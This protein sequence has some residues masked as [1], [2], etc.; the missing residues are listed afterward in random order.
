MTASCAGGGA[1]TSYSWSGPGVNPSAGASQVVNV[2]S[3]TTFSVIASNAAGSSAPAFANVTVAIAPPSACAL[4]ANPSQLPAGGGLVTLTASCSGGGAP[5]TY[6]WSGP[7]V[8]P[9]AGASQV[10]NVTATSTFSVVVSNAGGPSAPASTNVTVIPP[11]PTCSISANPG[12][13]VGPGTPVTMSANCTNNPTSFSWSANG[14]IVGQ[15]QVIN[16]APQ[17]TTT[18]TVTATNAGGSTSATYQVQVTSA[19]VCAVPVATPAGPVAAGTAV[20]VAVVCTNNPVSYRWTANGSPLSVNAPTIN[21]NPQVTTTYTV[22]AMNAGGTSSPPQSVTV[23]VDTQPPACSIAPSQPNPVAP[24]TAVTLTATCT[25]NA[26]N[27]TWTTGTGAPAG[28]GPTIAPAPTQT[29]TYTVSAS[30]AV[31]SGTAN[32]TIQVLAAPVCSV[33]TANPS[34]PVPAGTQ[35]TLTAS[36]TNSPV[37]Y[38]WTAN[39]VALAATTAVITNAP[40]ATTTYAV[41]ATNASGVSSPPQTVTVSVTAAPS[42][43]VNVSG[44]PPPTDSGATVP[45][46]VGVVDAQNRPVTNAQFA[47]PQIT[48]GPGTLTL[49]TPNPADGIYRFNFQLGAGDDTRRVTIC[50]ANDASKCVTYSVTTKAVVIIEPAKAIIAPQAVTA[51]STPTIQI[52]NI[53]QR[54]DQVRFQQ[55]P[56]VT[57]NLRVSLD[58]QSMPSLS[59]FALANDKDGKAPVGGGAAADDPFARWGV[60]V[61]GDVSIGKQS[62]VQSPGATQTGFKLTSKGVTVG[63]DYRLENNSVLGAAVG[64]LRADTDLYENMGTQDAKGYSFSLYGSWVPVPAAYVDLIFN[65]GHNTY[66]SQRTQMG[67]AD[68]ATSNT[69]GDQWG[70][71]LS[72]GYNFHQGPV[73]AVPYARVEYIDAKVDGFTE[74]G[75]PGE[76]LTVSEQRVKATTLSI[77]GQASYAISTTWGV[78]LPYGRVEFQHVAQS[79]VQTVYAGLVGALVPATLI[80]TLGQDKTFGNFAVGATALFGHNVSAFFNYEQ[81]FGQDDYRQQKYT[82]GFRYNF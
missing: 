22:T 70:V 9:N 74:S 8:N 41:T 64:F 50:L 68:P 55:Y 13:P 61:N 15:S 66:D 58:G 69:S 54:L 52:D 10:V 25:N 45:L 6:A 62:T 77:G 17:Q 2:S 59:A 82:L 29:T 76:A 3:S 65:V 31:G 47:P 21:A 43:I 33:P 37:S 44:N 60:F 34:G 11:P 72:A 30:N 81:L 35:V 49:V 4:A 24:G 51:V 19:P 18:Y 56:A 80:P 67:T 39:G 14:V 28:S 42:N 26:K 75:A 46:V 7:G 23:S 20:T 38:A 79:N 63:A 16:Q 78:L 1:P 32:Y 53:R 36:C 48:G 71:A 73:T 5:T 27:F 40:Q 12:N 57:Q